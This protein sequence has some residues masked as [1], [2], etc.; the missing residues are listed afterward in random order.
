MLGAYNFS[1]KEFSDEAMAVLNLGLKFVQSVKHKPAD[2]LEQELASFARNLR[3]RAQFGEGKGMKDL[4]YRVRNPAFVPGVASGEVE[5]FIADV[6]NTVRKC[7]KH[8]HSAVRSMHSNMTMAQQ[9][10]LQT[11]KRDRDIVIKP[12]DKNMGLCIVDKAW[13]MEECSKHLSDS[14]TYMPVQTPT[15]V[16]VD[17]VSS[18]LH[19]LTERYYTMGYME[20]E[21]KKFLDNAV[22]HNRDLPCMYLVPKVHKVTS[23]VDR[24]TGRTIVPGHS[25]VTTAAS[26]YMAS[27]LNEA[28]KACE[29]L[30]A[31]SRDLIKALDGMRVPRD[32]CLVSF[33]VESLFPNI[34]TNEAVQACAEMVPAHLSFMVTDFLSVIMKNNY[35][36]CIGQIWLSIF[37]TAQ[38]SPCSP[39]YANLYLAHIEKQLQE[40]APELWPML[41]KRFID[42]GFAIFASEAQA[43]EWLNRY[44]GMRPRINLKWVMSLHNINFMDLIIAKD[45]EA[46]GDT[47]PLNITTFQKVM[48]KYLYL[49]FTSHHPKHVFTGVIVGELIRYV[50]TNTRESDY[51]RM[52]LMFKDRLTR[53]GYPASLFDACAEKVSFSKR[54]EY[55]Y[56]S[57]KTADNKAY[58]TAF[59]TQFS[60]MH[61][62]RDVNVKCLLNEALARH[63]HHPKVQKLYPEGHIPLVYKKGRS[64]GQELVSAKHG[65]A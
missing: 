34:D 65:H 1:S 13:Y 21:V 9:R 29:Q 32:C 60:L 35:F 6:T 51:M 46:T 58:T 61:T 55:L 37:G 59:Y 39:P 23:P 53:R 4:A 16:I 19:V 2:Q 38:G 15:D 33:D 47:V 64:L 3:L 52:A 43:Q 57:R 18:K 36:R 8:E 5:D 20:E 24:L 56:G 14:A 7:F 50:V 45:M 25:W 44:Q 54:A 42:D 63:Y 11:L 12:A 62:A 49:P 41:F 27:I 31:D 40:L 17:E 28:S 10:A 22:E 48:N 26:K 30:L